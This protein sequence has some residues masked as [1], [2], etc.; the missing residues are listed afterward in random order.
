MIPEGDLKKKEHKQ[1]AMIGQTSAK[2]NDHPTINVSN[3]NPTV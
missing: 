2:P 3:S 1:A